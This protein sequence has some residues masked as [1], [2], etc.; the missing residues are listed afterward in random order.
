VEEILYETFSEVDEKH[1]WFVARTLIIEDLISHRIGLPR[2]STILDVGCGTGSILKKLS[3][4]YDC[5]GIDT[6]SKAIEF[7]RSKGLTNVSVATL[8]T[9][10]APV[11]GYDLILLLDVIEHIDDD[12][13][14]VRQASRLLNPRGHI[15]LTVPA[16]PFLW[17]KH[18]ELNQHKRR[19]VKQTLR[20]LLLRE[21]LS[22]LFLS[23]FNSLLFPPALVERMSQKLLR[24][25]SQKLLPLPPS[26][27]NNL[28]TSIFA[29]E[30][31]WL[32]HGSF[33]F[34][35]SLIALAKKA[36]GIEQER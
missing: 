2:N 3:E 15:L 24:R 19:Y 30:K 14:A 28:L 23:Y 7:C 5:H 20:Q 22:V 9:C 18:D 8:E 16:Y 29:S 31:L 26:P 1:W 36:T 27:I 35:L 34:G 11:G 21:G 33:P 25:E 6:S 13:Q 17:S 32:R 12:V 4:N 10:A